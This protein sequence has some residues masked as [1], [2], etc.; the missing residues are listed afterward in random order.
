MDMPPPVPVPVRLDPAGRI[1]EDVKCIRCGYNLRGLSANGACPECGTAVGRS[2]Q[3]DLLQFSPPEW[4]EQLASGM[5]WIVM[6]I[7]I[8]IFAGLLVGLMAG[9][10]GLNGP[11]GY[12]IQ[13]LGIVGVIGYWK[14][15]SPDPASIEAEPPVTARKLVRFVAVFNYVFGFAAEGMG[16][17]NPVPAQVIQVLVGLVGIVGFF[18]D[19]IYARRLALRIPN[20]RLAMHTRI[21]MWGLVA[22]TGLMVIGGLATIAMF[23]GSGTT[24]GVVSLVLCPTSLGMITFAIWALVLL[25]WFRRELSRAAALARQTWARPVAPP[26]SGSPV[27]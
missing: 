10:G 18:A 19:F 21:V 6:S 15:A 5:N 25:I 3:G 8:G 27:T 11:G 23:S 20:P 13:A 16:T 14:V 1:D 2:L 4:V 17:V 24:S 7:V 9:R 26:W 12:V 22:S